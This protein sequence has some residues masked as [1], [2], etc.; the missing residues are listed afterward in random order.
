M[1]EW[2]AAIMMCSKDTRELKVDG[3]RN[4]IAFLGKEVVH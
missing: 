1:N 3:F 4:Q 2:G